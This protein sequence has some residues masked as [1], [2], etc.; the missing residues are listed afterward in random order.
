MRR[1]LLVAAA[2]TALLLAA[3]PAQAMVTR[4]V[5]TPEN[6]LYFAQENSGATRYRAWTSDEGPNRFGVWYRIGNQ[7][8]T[9]LTSHNVNAFLGGLT[10]GHSLGDVISF[11]SYTDQTRDWN[12]RLFD[13]SGHHNI[14]VPA[15]VNTERF[16]THPTL[17]GN[18]LLFQRGDVGGPNRVLLYDL[19]SET[20][21][22][23][24]VAAPDEDVFASRV[25]GD[26]AVYYVCNPTRCVVHR[27]RISTEEDV[28]LPTGGRSAYEP[29]VTT[30]G[31]VYYVIGHPT[32]CGLTTTLRRWTGGS[33][34]NIE[35]LPTGIDVASTWSVE[36]PGGAVSL[37]F[38]RIV[39]LPNG[40]RSGIYATGG[41][42]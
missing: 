39:C 13:L 20:V 26:Y 40:Y 17:S 16:E 30:T 21:T 4:V 41:A 25:N 12:V 29:T 9:R 19:T 27:Y 24:A 11:D 32:K 31:A 22:P 18:F 1:R 8:K 5:D 14:P 10:L 37:F 2:V 28:A 35:T 23:L 7:P 3:S 42:G 34:L 38:T 36:K 33:A 15:A 6:E